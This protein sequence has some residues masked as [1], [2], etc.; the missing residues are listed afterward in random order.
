[1]PK[2]NQDLLSRLKTKLGVSTARMYALIQEI[3]AKNRVPR[4][5]GALLLAGDYGI[6]QQKYATAEE[7]S[8]LRGIPSHVPVAAEP[9]KAASVAPAPVRKGKAA[10]VPKTKENTVFV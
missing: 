8:E 1:M 10:K 4:H 7:L 2:I 6:S 3:S 9:A 5:L